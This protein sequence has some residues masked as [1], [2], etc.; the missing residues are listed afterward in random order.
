M[1]ISLSKD[2]V[3]IIKNIFDIIQAIATVFAI[4]IGGI[5]SYMLFIRKRQKYPR[6]NITHNITH[7]QIGNK[8]ILLHVAVTITNVGD[9]LIALVSG[10]T[11]IQQILPLSLELLKSINQGDKL[12]PEGNTEI[13]WPIIDSRESE[14]QNNQIEPGE[15]DQLHYDFILDDSIKIIEIYSHFKNAKIPQ[16][17]IGWNTTTIYDIS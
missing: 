15:N 3:E 4:I 6:A 1:C 14:W 12:P 13:E 11:R 2:N 17:D 16:K 9:V 10:E 8:K 7:R 5:W